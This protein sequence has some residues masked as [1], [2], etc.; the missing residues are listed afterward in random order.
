M[1]R[2]FAVFVGLY[3][4]GRRAEPDQGHQHHDH[5][6][7]H[8]HHHNPEE[9]QLALHRDP[10]HKLAQHLLKEESVVQLVA[11]CWES[12]AITAA[13]DAPAGRFWNCNAGVSAVP[14]AEPR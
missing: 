11:S 7:N 8:K 1:P 4:V 12:Q 5:K 3:S 13:S 9:Q 6:Y 14:P 2:L 10:Q